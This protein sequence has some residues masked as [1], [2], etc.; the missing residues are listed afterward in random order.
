MRCGTELEF[1]EVAIASEMESR[2]RRT[3]A[4]SRSG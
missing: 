2:K 3:A 4:T 1:P